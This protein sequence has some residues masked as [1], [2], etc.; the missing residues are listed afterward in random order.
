[1]A[2]ERALS[3]V[4]QRRRLRAE[5][6]RAR[7]DAGLTQE[8][9]AA[10]MDWSLSKII[11]I[12]AG[13]VGISTNDLKALLQHYKITDAD[14]IEMLVALARGARERSWWS[15]YGDVAS[16]RL[17][18]YIEYEAAAYTMRNFQPLV[19]PGLLQ[20]DEYAQAMFR[21]L[22]PD[23]PSGR[24]DALVDLRMRRQELLEQPEAAHFLFVIDEAVAHRMVGSQN[25]MRQQL[26]RLIDTA[27]NSNVSLELVPFSAGLHPGLAG[28]FVL[29]EF[30]DAED[31]DVLYLETN[32]GD[33]I[34]QDDQEEIFTYRETFEQLRSRSLGPEG[35]IAF[36]DRIVGELG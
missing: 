3:P 14:T 22:A 30:G 34:K 17:L 28:S 11:R 8:Q 9:V 19:V 2:A 24:V 27:G 31:D 7:Q 35:S 1:M 33:F 29:L 10:A 26:R 5:L 16:Q 23:A 4:V 25:V 36:I 20:T 32:Q 12:E 6:R 18:Q 13:S 15:G 21:Q